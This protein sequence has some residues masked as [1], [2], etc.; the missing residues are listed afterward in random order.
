MAKPGVPVTEEKLTN[1][2]AFRRA[3]GLCDICTEKWFWGHKC[4]ATIPLQAM[5]E[6]WNLFQIE[7]LSDR[8]DIE[9]DTP[10]ETLEQLFLAL[11]VDALRGSPGR[12]TIQF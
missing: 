4:A 5:Q 12:Q 10:V 11:S 7:D 9:Q 3:Q 6:V 2:H 8:T 1:L